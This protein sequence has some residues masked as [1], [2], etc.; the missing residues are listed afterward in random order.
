MTSI[1]RL[2]IDENNRQRWAP[3][4]DT[5]CDNFEYHVD[6]SRHFIIENGHAVDGV[7]ASRLVLL[8]YPTARIFHARAARREKKI[9][10]EGVSAACC[11]NL[12]FRVF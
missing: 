1:R 9:D 11:T 8:S 4:D 6:A 12:S 5:N 7:V 10:R 3:L 2:G